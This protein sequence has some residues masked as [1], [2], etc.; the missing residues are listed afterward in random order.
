MIVHI[1][2]AK[3]LWFHISDAGLPHGFLEWSWLAI[4][5]AG[6]AVFGFRFFFQWLHSEKHGESKIPISFWWMSVIGTLLSA[7]Y[8]MHKSQF[9]A[10][11]GNG[12][13][14]IPYIRNLV[15]VYRKKRTD[16]EVAAAAG[17]PVEPTRVPQPS[18][19]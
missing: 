18:Q 16:A 3:V 14:L 15:L 2:A 10:L 17:F 6:Q 19:S 8:F 13:Q 12:P 11:L 5:L 4:G 9:V 1:L 7:A